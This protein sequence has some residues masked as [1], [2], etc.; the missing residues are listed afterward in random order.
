MPSGTVLRFRLV[1]EVGVTSF[2]GTSRGHISSNFDYMAPDEVD[3]EAAAVVL[4]EHLT[5]SLKGI[6]PAWARFKGATVRHPAQSPG[7]VDEVIYTPDPVDGE[8]VFGTDPHPVPMDVAIV[9]Q[10]GTGAPGRSGRGRFFFAPVHDFYFDDN[11]DG[12][13]NADHFGLVARCETLLESVVV[14]SVGLTPCLWHR[15]SETATA[16]TYYRVAER[17]GRLRG[18]KSLAFL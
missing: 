7:V 4:W 2:G 11:L 18:R 10:R 16:L 1:T 13:V 17:I 14:G 8:F 3:F 5:G 6:L 9:F 15:E 12:R